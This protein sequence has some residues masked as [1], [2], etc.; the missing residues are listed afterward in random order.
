[1]ISTFQSWVATLLT[2][3]AWVPM[4]Q[5]QDRHGQDSESSLTQAG[6]T[7]NIVDH[8]SFMPSIIYEK[9][10]TKVKR[11][12]EIRVGDLWL[13]YSKLFHRLIGIVSLSSWLAFHDFQPTWE[14]PSLGDVTDV[15]R[16]F[17]KW[18]MSWS[19]TKSN[20]LLKITIVDSIDVRGVKPRSQ[21]PLLMMVFTSSAAI[22][23]H[24][25]L[26][27]WMLQDATYL[28]S[29]SHVKLS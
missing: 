17:M 22:F 9:S 3:S 2:L 27:T 24:A 13:D 12:R 7:N 21:K 4:T 8:V 5:V 14:L 19:A 6:C 28:G 29:V 11:S 15:F 16:T 20:I 23:L 10:I 25:A 18:V 1:M 26:A